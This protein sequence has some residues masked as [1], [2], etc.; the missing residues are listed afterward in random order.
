MSA[1]RQPLFSVTRDLLGVFLLLFSL[2]GLPC[3]ECIAVFHT[4]AIA[5]LAKVAKADVPIHRVDDRNDGKLI[6]L[7]G[8]VTTDEDLEFTPLAVSENA[9]RLRWNT[10]IYQW[11][12]ERRIESFESESESVGQVSFALGRWAR[13]FGSI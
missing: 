2:V 8:L 4:T 13:R 11:V 9:I 6:H 12:E 1:S 3:S 10:S 7:V 5:Q